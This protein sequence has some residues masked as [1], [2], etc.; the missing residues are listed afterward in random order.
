MSM[1]NPFSAFLRKVVH[2]RQCSKSIVDEG[3]PAL[4]RLLEV[5][6]DD[7]SQSCV[8]AVFLLGLYD[9]AR[10]PFPLTELRTVDHMLFDDVQSVLRMDAQACPHKIH[11]Y[12]CGG[13]EIFE[14]LAIDWDVRDYT[15]PDGN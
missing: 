4:H 11:H 2:A 10:F 5:A 14:Q 13:E 7:T 12:L 3:L 6:Q 15:R 1:P 8:V 9:A